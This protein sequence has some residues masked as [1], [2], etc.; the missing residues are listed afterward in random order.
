[1]MRL[2]SLLASVLAY[3]HGLQLP[4]LGRRIAPPPPPP[5]APPAAEAGLQIACAAS[6]LALTVPSLTSAGPIVQS[7][8]GIAQETF[9]QKLR[10]PACGFLEITSPIFILEAALLLA[11]ARS[12]VGSEEK[13]RVGGALG[14]TGAMSLALL[15]LAFASGLS[16]AQPAAVGGGVAL[17]AA[18]TVLG[19]RAATSV[20]EPAALLK[21]DAQDLLPIVAGSAPDAPALSEGQG[22]AQLAFFYR[23]STLV[24]LVVGASFIASPV[25]P[26]ALFDTPEAP[27]THWLRQELGVYICF[28]LAPVQAALYRAARAGELGRTSNRILNLV[29]GVV[30]SLLVLDGRYQVNLGGAAFAALE[31]GTPLYEA[32]QVQLADPQAVGRASTNTTAAFSV[33]LIVGLVYLL[34]ALGK[35]PQ[36][37]E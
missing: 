11:L 16:V 15:F 24:G 4:T 30:C 27:V 13:A 17:I 10:E 18:T 33:G 12:L 8:F 25:S 2:L 21:S 28:L 19:M 35:K 6:W 31:P 3:A 36:A 29:T 26:I 9:E 22:D 23:G 37:S 34:T 20:D 5:P 14:L 7:S 1:M 32:I